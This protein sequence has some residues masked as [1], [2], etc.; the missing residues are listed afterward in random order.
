MSRNPI[1][2]FVYLALPLLVLAG[3]KPGWGIQ[4]RISPS[5][6]IA[7]V[8]SARAELAA[9]RHWH[10]AALLRSVFPQGPEDS[11]DLRILMARAEAGWKN[12]S[13]VHALLGTVADP[14]ILESADA[15]YLLGRALEGEGRWEEADS[16]YSR[17]LSLAGEGASDGAAEVLARRGRVRTRL[18]AYGGALDDARE[19][20]SL[21][22]TVGSWVSL[23]IAEAAAEA[24]EREVTRVALG[25]V[26]VEAV[27]QRGWALP[28]AALLAAGDSTGAEAS[29]WS[30]LPGLRSSA[31]KAEAWDRVGGLRLARRDSAGAQGAFRQVLVHARSSPGAVR[32][33]ESLLRLGFDSLATALEGARVLQGAGRHREALE[34]LRR[35]EERSGELPPPWARLIQARAHLGVGEGRRALALA[36]DLAGAQDPAMALA[37]QILEIDALRRLGRG[38]EQ[39]AAQDELLERFPESPEAVEMVYRRATTLQDRGD[40]EG[41]IQ[42]YRETTELAP[43]LNLAGEARMK[44][45]YLFLDMDRDQEALSV[46]RDYRED[47]PDGRRW[48]QA[49]FWEA[50]ILYST[51]EEERP[52]E[53]LDTLREKVPFSYYSVVAGDLLG[54]PFD[55]PVPSSG[56]SLPFP[57]LLADGLAAV[58]RLGEAGLEAGAE[59]EVHALAQRIRD[60]P[61]P[62]RRSGALL[63]LALE[64]ND[65][66]FTREGI[67]LGWEI[68]REG[69]PMDRLLAS[70]IYPLPY[71]DILMAE[72]RERGADPYLLAGLIRQES[73]FWARAVSRADARGLMQVLPSTGAALARG[74][75]PEGF[76]A[77][78]HLFDPEINIHLGTA[79]FVDMR[80]RFGESL[81]IIL[82]AYNAGPT[83]ATRWRRFPEVSDL[84]RFVE[85]IPFSETRGYVKN[86][87]ANRAIYTWLYAGAQVPGLLPESSRE[88]DLRPLP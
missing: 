37:A 30:A 83:R 54:A 66:G 73:A 13:G 75:G 44:L 67:N 22:P 76:R 74:Q 50:R 69:R 77:D 26:A 27:R 78:D 36:R 80:R 6:R 49:A 58:D 34:V 47:F 79:F 41:A 86:V 7:S 14:V 71:R 18:G 39:R 17:F 55:P 61:D 43:A 25:A 42:A 57:R 68:R 1:Q 64:L 84:P 56:D 23:G 33:A 53:L 31:E 2:S 35:Y 46:F 24:G 85:K 10:A 87:T 82:S 15:W 62:E 3:P 20:L 8:D 9:G 16:A 63:R 52:R 65:R 4:E 19:L 81:P 48:D 5:S 38:A 29:F 32:A 45:G 11:D 51:G 88:R 59:G 70:A 28:G 60:D 12:W 21:D 40:L 72:A